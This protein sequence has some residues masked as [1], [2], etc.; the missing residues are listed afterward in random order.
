MAYLSGCHIAT[1]GTEGEAS[2]VVLGPADEMSLLPGLRVVD[3]DRRAG[4]IGDE[5]ANRV[6]RYRAG[7]LCGADHPLELCLESR[8]FVEATWLM[9]SP[10][11]MFADNYP[12][13]QFTSLTKLKACLPITPLLT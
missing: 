13:T 2:D 12:L 5:A 6:H 7:A 1:V 9:L 4:R 8:L 3:D 11:M 10:L